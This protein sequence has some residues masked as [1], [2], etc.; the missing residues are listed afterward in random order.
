MSDPLIERVKRALVEIEDGPE[1]AQLLIDARDAARRA[2]QR[3]DELREKIEKDEA[4]THAL[5]W[6]V[7]DLMDGKP[8]D[9]VVDDLPSPARRLVIAARHQGLSI[10][11]I[12]PSDQFGPLPYIRPRVSVMRSRV[13]LI[14]VEPAGCGSTYRQA[15]WRGLVTCKRPLGHEGHHSSIR[16]DEERRS[17]MPKYWVWDSGP[18]ENRPADLRQ[19]PD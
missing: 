7:A 18:D 9:D 2:E 11:W 3:A 6:V 4:T 17:G 13:R 5:A 10:G 1:I 16:D 12:K 14:D 19:L 15:E 8:V